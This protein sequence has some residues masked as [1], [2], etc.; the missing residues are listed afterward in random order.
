MSHIKNL[1]PLEAWDLLQQTE[2][3]V[4]LDVRDP[5]EFLLVG[6][7]AGAVNVPWKFAPEWKPNLNF[8]EQVKTCVPDREGAIFLLCRSGQRS[9][10]AAQVLSEEG[11]KHLINIDEGFEGSLNE[12][13][14]RGKQG[15]WRF[16]NLPWEQS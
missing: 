9:L 13:K 7:P 14:Q 16:H 5:L 10:D 8:V 2:N 12:N 3:A 1:N 11:Y 4:L 6:H 15:G